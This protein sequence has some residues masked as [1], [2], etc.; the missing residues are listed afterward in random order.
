MFGDDWVRRDERC[1]CLCRAIEERTSN[2][3]HIIAR[4]FL[5]PTGSLPVCYCAHRLV[6]MWLSLCLIVLLTLSLVFSLDL[7]ATGMASLSL[8]APRRAA[9]SSSSGIRTKNGTSSCVCYRYPI[10][11]VCFY[12]YF[13][14]AIIWRS[15]SCRIGGVS[16][17]SRATQEVV[18]APVVGSLQT[19]TLLHY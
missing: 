18:P 2:M 12:F 14:F 15:V 17:D 7:L 10:F 5:I 8:P 11:S 4:I 3:S 16:Y 13:S 9:P 19:F 1:S 6:I